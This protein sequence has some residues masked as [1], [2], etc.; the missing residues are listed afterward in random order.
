MIRR[1]PAVLGFL[2]TVPLLLAA[3]GKKADPKKPAEPPPDI[4]ADINKPRAD[5]RKVAFEIDEGT[6][7]SLDVSPDGKTVVFDLL[8]DLY[9][10]PIGGGAATSLTSGPAFDMQPRFSP[11]GNTIA[12]TS[13]RNGIDNLW[14]VDAD[15]KNPRAV[16][17]EKGTYVRGPAWTPDGQYVIGR[18][19]DG[20]RAGIPPIELWVYHR[21]G[22][23]GVKLTS[24]D[25]ASSSAGPVA[26]KDGR[27]IY[28]AAR[29][30]PYS[31]VP[32]LSNG[33]WQVFRYDRRTAESLPITTGVGGATRPAVSPDGKTLVFVSRIDNATVLV[34]RDLA[35]GKERVLARDLSR[36][37]QEGFA[38]MDV[39]PGYAF[40][41]DGSA[42][43]SWSGG[44]IR[45]FDAATGASTVIPFSAKV[46]QWLAPRVA[47]QEKIEG[48]P[49]RSRILRSANVSPDG[50]HVVFGAMGRSGSR[51]WPTARPR[52]RRAASPRRSPTPGSTRRPFPPMARRSRT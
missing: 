13:D 21:E 37:E 41:P 27:F 32:D 33:L 34:S 42:I 12:F 52:A 7:M 49:F 16:T 15:G 20:T 22:G 44:K 36:D 38:Q 14:L 9:T 46:E 19:E 50:K 51:T 3:A 39:W 28:F 26:S 29:K 6:W 47:W 4:A 18:K 31:Y 48:D 45:R 24:K 1:F 8:G 25:D 40:T 23:S 43:V 11:D 30:G 5:A 10:M 2:A 35:S 17:S